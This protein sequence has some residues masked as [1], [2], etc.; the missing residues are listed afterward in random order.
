MTGARTYGD[1]SEG[2][3]SGLV[4]SLQGNDERISGHKRP[5]SH[6]DIPIGGTFV[7]GRIFLI[8]EHMRKGWWGTSSESSSKTGFWKPSL[9]LVVPGPPDVGYLR[10][11]VRQNSFAVGKTMTFL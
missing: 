4:P 8:A 11:C 10:Q 1:D 5:Q 9:M 2:A 7:G 3:Q 6:C